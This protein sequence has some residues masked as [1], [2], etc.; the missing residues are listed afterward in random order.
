MINKLQSWTDTWQ[1]NLN[2]DKCVTVSYGR[3]VDKS[4]S[5]YLRR[6]GTDCALLRLDS[7]KD[8]GVLLFNQ[9]CP[10]KSILLIRLIKPAACLALSKETL[11][12]CHYE[13]SGWRPLNK[14]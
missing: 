4:H 12:I 1:L 10:L 14:G 6:G 3:Q 8:L 2:V 13:V 5:Y 11:G 9:I 7:F